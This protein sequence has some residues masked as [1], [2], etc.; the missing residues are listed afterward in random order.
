MSIS[1]DLI[2]RA[3][4]LLIIKQLKTKKITDK[5]AKNL[6]PLITELSPKKIQCEIILKLIFPYYISQMSNFYCGV[7]F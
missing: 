1:S 4:T 5:D 2:V 6:S 3:V 7:F